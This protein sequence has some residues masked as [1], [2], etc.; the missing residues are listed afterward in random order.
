MGRRR[1]RRRPRKG[2]KSRSNVRTENYADVRVVRRVV[3][4]GG[5]GTGPRFRVKT[6]RR[7]NGEVTEEFFELYS[8]SHEG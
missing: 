6:V 1:R 4:R 3:R 7:R 2:R 5:K 8:G